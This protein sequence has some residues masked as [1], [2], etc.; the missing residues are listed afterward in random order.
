MWNSPRTAVLG[1]LVAAL[2]GAETWTVP[3]VPEPIRAE[4]TGFVEADRTRLNNLMPPGTRLVVA[5]FAMPGKQ[6]A[7]G[8]QVMEFDTQLV[9]RELP[10]KASERDEA[11]IRYRLDLLKL[12][13]ERA[14][15]VDQIA[16]ATADLATA[17]A[18]LAAVGADDAAE[19]ALARSRADL[20]A[21]EAARAERDLGRMRV[22][23]DSGDASAQQLADAVHAAAVARF[24]AEKSAAAAARVAGRDRSAERGRLLLDEARL[25]GSLGL[26]RDAGGER[27]DPAQ[28]LPARLAQNGS[29]RIA[30]EAALAGE[31]DARRTAWQETV[32][33]LH[34]H[35]P[36]GA[37]ELVPAAGEPI[38]VDLTSGEPASGWK[39]DD[40]A[41]FDAVRG[42]GWDRDLRGRFA[43][44]GAKPEDTWCLVRG[45]AVWSAT[46]PDGAWTLR[47][48]LGSDA[49]WGGVVVRVDGGEGAKS[50]YVSN[51][52]AANQHPVAE[53]PV[54]VHGGRLRLL[55]GGE[56]GRHLYAPVAGTFL[57]HPRTE[58]GRKVDWRG[59][60]LCYIVEPAAV[61]ISARAPADVA[62]LLT[63][64]KTADGDL[65]TRSATT[66][67][68]VVPPGQASCIGTV[69]SVGTKPAGTR[70]GPGGWNEEEPGAPQ[71]LTH[72][73]V[74]VGLPPA[75]AAR[76]GLR[77][78]V[79]VRVAAVPPAGIA[80]VPPWMVAW[81][82]SS[83]WIR[84]AGAW[85]KVEAMRA[86]PRTLV[87]GLEPGTTLHAPI[88][89]PPA[90]EAV[91]AATADADGGF[92]G[93]VVAGER[94]RV[95]QLGGWGR[96]ATFVA[97]GSEV[98]AGD[99]LLTLYNP[100]IDQQRDQLERERR[101]SDRSFA[102]AAAARRERL[103]Q[104]GDQRRE[105]QIA[106]G[107]ARFALGDARRPDD[108][109]AEAAVGRARGE[110][111]AAHARAAEGAMRGLAVPPAGEL[112]DR[113][114]DAER[115]RVADER[116]ALEEAR[117]AN[118]KDWL[119][120]A[121]ADGAWREALAVLGQK[122]AKDLLARAE[123]RA[124]TAKAAAALEGSRQGQAWIADFDRN[125]VLRSPAAG[126]LYWLL[127]WNDQTRSRG[128]LTKD[129]W[130]WGGMPVAEIVD[131]GRLSFT[132]ELPEALYPRMAKGL[133]ARVRFP[134]LG[135][136]R[137]AATVA[138][139]GQALA[140]PRDAAD[141]GLDE[142]VADLRV[143][144]LTL[145][146][147]I[148]P[149]ARGQVQPGLR[150][151]L[152]LP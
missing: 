127:A 29:K 78:R 23:S 49:E 123:D 36:L 109:L 45:A 138:N 147:A 90:D 91:P 113:A 77:S 143:F 81:R 46:L 101:Q 83:A 41:P 16:R 120:A 55:I 128:K 47:L 110:L 64:V 67:V 13:R 28:G 146:L 3:A 69:A 99:E 116:A 63:V 38:R 121:D 130:V 70:T 124:A 104:A 62:A 31:R 30:Q 132:V 42:W 73:E 151:I 11:E 144:T 145:D 6:V 148:P 32:R 93:E 75:D 134:V 40:G 95:M 51:Q 136:R 66:T 142:K 114:A 82:A 10:Q 71:D 12:D 65:R 22:R 50:A 74:F 76:A 20:A 102:E 21:S 86:G 39:R 140:A 85:R 54:T 98:K 137:L 19:T 97:D 118:A 58:R 61:R 125:K 79:A 131:M 25:M 35:C 94:V 89:E 105:D 119:A 108:G 68:E 84:V 18:R 34:D 53:V 7:A 135:D 44:S 1:L 8:E 57:L 149:D 17:R 106:E 152:E 24:A 88:G 4:F 126:R 100:V 9:E 27:A 59:R 139:V 43:G 115:A 150:G 72:R 117:T 129:V 103:I 48:T 56:P 60:P 14:D 122:E 133:A 33:E 26:V 5:R 15:L 96:V 80:V 111:D 92:A 2:P 37:I 107:R 141:A 52:L 112:A 87:A